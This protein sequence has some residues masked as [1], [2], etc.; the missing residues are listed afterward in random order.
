MILYRPMYHVPNNFLMVF[1]AHQYRRFHRTMN[2]QAQGQEASSQNTGKNAPDTDGNRRHIR[3][4]TWHVLLQTQDHQMK[5]PHPVLRDYRI[6]ACCDILTYVF[7][8]MQNISTIQKNILARYHQHGRKLPRRKTRD[9][10]AIH[11][12]E[13]MLQQTQVER[14][15]PYFQ[16]WMEDFPDYQTLA[17][18]SKADVLKHRS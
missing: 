2:R 7:P 16:Q 1:P 4:I 18:A 14:V 12:S 15:I 10:Y 6:A 11:V 17:K 9:P 8:L 3:C 13:V 5:I